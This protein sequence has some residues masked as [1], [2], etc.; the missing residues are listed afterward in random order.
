MGR[1]RKQDSLGPEIK[2][3]IIDAALAV[4]IEEGVSGATYRRVAARTGF[5]PGT[6]TYH[7]G[8]INE[9]VAA[10]FLRLSERIAAIYFDK[11]RE[12]TDKARAREVV[13][14]LICGDPGET[15]R[16]TLL[17]LELHAFV[18]RFPEYMHLMDDWLARSRQALQTHF[19]EREARAIDA[20]AGGFILHNT[21]GKGAVAREEVL[22]L[23][24]AVS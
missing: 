11:L 8:G 4:I 6:L 18:S 5:S 2:D 9:I 12:A 1:P 7:F 17:V 23:V 19:D 14:D 22:R 20:L 21:L 13:A 15:P 3:V 10:A 24:G 16:Q